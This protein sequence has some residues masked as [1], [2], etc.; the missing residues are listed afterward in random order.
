MSGTEYQKISGPYKRDPETNLI[1]PGAW[2]DPSLQ[3]LAYSDDWYF[4]EKVDGTNVRV[5]WDGYTASYAGRTDR[6]SF[7]SVQASALAKFFA[8]ATRETLFEQQFRG[9]P[10]VLYGELYGPG[11]QSGGIYRD[12]LSFILFDVKVGDFW[13]H[14]DDVE[15][16][17]LGLGVDSVPVILPQNTIQDAINVVQDGFKSIVAIRHGKDTFA[18]GLVGA[19]NAG[20]LDRRGNRVAVKVKHQ[21]FYR[22]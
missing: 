10:A 8:G 19:T 12:D 17:A 4:T 6:A 22:G 16:V 15:D 14:R 20:L 18:E 11:V 2:F 5:L 13:L 21:D 9:N 3:A 7:S 1:I